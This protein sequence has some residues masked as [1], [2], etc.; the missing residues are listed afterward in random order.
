MAHGGYAPTLGFKS[1]E[2]DST[3]KSLT[4]GPHIRGSLGQ[5][6]GFRLV[7]SEPGF[8]WTLLSGRM[9]RVTTAM[10][11]MTQPGERPGPRIPGPPGSF[12]A[13]KLLGH[14]GCQLSEAVSLFDF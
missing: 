2:S 12:T 11:L 1:K 4:T 3:G 9:L 7:F 6:R 10:T 5:K 14:V 13:R 8:L